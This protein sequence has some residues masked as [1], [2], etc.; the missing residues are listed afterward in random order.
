[1]ADETPSGIWNHARA[2]ERYVGRWS[3]RVAPLF[4]SWLEI[5]AA[6]HWLDVGCG[7]GALSAA[8][9]DSCSPASIHG[10]EPSDGFLASARETLDGRVVFHTGTAADIPLH[11][12]SADVVVSGLVLNFV[13]DA[14]EALVEMGRVAKRG[15]TL[16]AYVWDYGERMELMRYFWDSAIALDPAVA[17]VAESRRFAL[18]NPD[19]LRAA[20]AAASLTAVEVTAVDIVTEFASFDDY[21]DPFLGGQGPAPAYLVALDQSHRDALRARLLRSLPIASDGSIAL[22]ARA[23]A[24]R[25][26]KG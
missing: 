8:I 10:V 14:V 3:R 2:Y 7:T 19:A 22:I 1:M 15:G 5:P 26:A 17:S 11:S 20:F 21:W 4:L 23:W 12:S 24:V 9:A 16:A 25:G 6:R 13:P 18:C